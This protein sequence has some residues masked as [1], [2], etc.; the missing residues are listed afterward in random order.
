MMKEKTMEF[1]E[2]CKETTS[3][4]MRGLADPDTMSRMTA[5]EFSAA[6]SMFKMIN[7]SMDLMVVQAELMDDMNRKLD[8]L[9][10][11]G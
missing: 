7:A 6:Q 2:Q 4:F 8:K 1:V 10:Q 11:K 9:L 3:K 5:E